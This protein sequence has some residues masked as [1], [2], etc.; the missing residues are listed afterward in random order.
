MDQLV[1]DQGSDSYAHMFIC[2]AQGLI[3]ETQP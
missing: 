3:Y 1:K 2:Q